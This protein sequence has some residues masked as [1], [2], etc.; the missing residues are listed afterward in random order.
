[1]LQWSPRIAGIGVALFLAMFALDVFTGR[2]WLETLLALVIHLVPTFLVLG[3][4]ALAWRWPLVGA[5]A[6]PVLAL[7]YAVM[8][9][10]RL[11]WVA[12]IGGPLLV[13]GALYVASWRANERSE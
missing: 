5:V 11:D 8:V 6:F 9:H 7:V 4:V 13:V 2:P 12:A 3:V 10:W 1:V